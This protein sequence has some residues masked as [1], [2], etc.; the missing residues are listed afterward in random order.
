MRYR[1]LIL[2]LLCAVV[3]GGE[4]VTNGLFD[5]DSDWN[6]GDA[7]WTIAG[8]VATIS[9]AQAG[10]VDLTQ[11]IS[12]LTSGQMYRINY[13]CT[14]RAAGA[15][16]L[17]FDGANL[18]SD[19]AAATYEVFAPAIGTSADI[20]IRSDADT[21]ASFDIV[22]V[23]AM[24]NNAMNSY[25]GGSSS[26]G[27]HATFSFLSA[28]VSTGANGES[29]LED[30]GLADIS[31]DAGKMLITTAADIANDMTGGYC[32]IVVNN[33]SEGTGR[34]QILSH[35]QSPGGADTILIDL[36]WVDD[37]VDTVN[38]A[39]GGAVPVVDAT[40][41]LQDVLDDSLGSAVANNVDIYITGTGTLT[42][43]LVID[44]GG[45]S[46]TTFKRLIGADASYAPHGRGT[47]TVLTA[48][49]ADLAGTPLVQ[50][51]DISY[52]I[53]EN[54]EF[55]LFGDAATSG[56]DCFEI[57]NTTAR[58]NNHFFNCK[59]DSGYIGLNFGGSSKGVSYSDVAGCTVVGHISKAMDGVNTN[60]RYFN[61]YIKG[62][63]ATMVELDGIGCLVSGNII[64]GGG[65]GLYFPEN[66]A[67][68][69]IFNNSFYNQTSQCIGANDARVVRM[70]V[71]NNLFWVAD[72]DNDEPIESTAGVIFFVEED[73]N[74]TNAVAG[75]SSMLTGA[76]S[77]HTRWSD[78][79]T[80]VWRDA[81]NDDFRIAVTIPTGN[82]AVVDAGRPTRGQEEHTTAGFSTIGAYQLA[83]TQAGGGGR[84][85]GIGK[86][87]GG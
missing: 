48:D 25:V 52:T 27:A 87:I 61:N 71:W 69:E 72:K 32:N 81:A 41:D 19:D 70:C 36:T 18:G 75:Q 23:V 21:D 83:Q 10:A 15:F 37:G 74:K 13:T 57:L 49:T 84:T 44:A 8:G 45:G 1:F 5:A 53:I 54:I 28:S 63:T 3:L 16:T 42:S 65:I 34:F 4:E 35:D 77:K 51:D 40:F 66:S 67:G 22:S 56:E 33:G 9:G 6:K 38:I 60:G 85:P 14:V 20:I 29:V 7:A 55:T 31:G 59:F 47:Y 11:T 78:T 86:G 39:I 80:N 17:L 64:S 76:N 30:T 43:T 12:G 26:N 82:D 46:T 73:Y 2:F 68:Y 58:T 24:A 79:E 50:I 62:T